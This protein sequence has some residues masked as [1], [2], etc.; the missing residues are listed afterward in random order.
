MISLLNRYFVPVYLSN[1]D[2]AKDGPAPSEDKAERDRIYR[3]ALKAQLSTGTVHVYIL[4]ADG[5]PIDS[6]HVAAASKVDKLT[7]MLERTVEKLKLQEG[8]PLVKPVTQS[9]APKAD[10]DALVLH[11]T[12]RNLTRQAQKWLPVKP[13]LGE[14]RSGNWG[15]YAVEDWIVLKKDEWGK[16]LPESDVTA[17]TAWDPDKEV[18][19]KVLRHFYPSTEN[20]NVAKNRIDEQQFR[21]TVLSV[22]DGVVRARIDGALKMKHPFYHKDD[23]NV[24]DATI[25]GILDYD[26]A[27]KKIR[28][29]QL[30]TDKANYGRTTF[31]VVVRSE[32]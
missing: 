7:E 16:L 18:A 24:V 31:G 17:G 22:K 6:Q 12:A 26:Q 20:N 32:P 10:A 28:S 11:L 27:T 1:E 5:H 9:V 30:A 4:D 13:T 2:Y 21:A 14:T 29:L 8:K 15:A 23:D 25:V 19:A 3:E